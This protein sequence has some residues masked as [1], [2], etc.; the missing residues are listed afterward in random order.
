MTTASAVGSCAG[1][2]SSC[3]ACFPIAAQFTTGKS[4]VLLMAG[5]NFFEKSSA[6]TA[7]ETSRRAGCNASVECDTFP[8]A[9]MFISISR[10]YP[11]TMIRNMA[12]APHPRQFE[13]GSPVD[14]ARFLAYRGPAA[15]ERGSAH[16]KLTALNAQKPTLRNPARAGF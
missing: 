8:V 15:D 2:L 3:G 9:G 14:L 16:Q 6:L 7:A 12:K 13:P 11:A 4:G 10:G 1:V 5:R